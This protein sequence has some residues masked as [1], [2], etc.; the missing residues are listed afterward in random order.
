MTQLCHRNQLV[1]RAQKIYIDDSRFF[2]FFRR[3]QGQARDVEQ[4]TEE[5]N[6]Q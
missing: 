4:E 5:R 1:S 6:V 3:A 2:F